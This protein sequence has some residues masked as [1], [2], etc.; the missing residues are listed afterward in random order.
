MM[1]IVAAL[2]K[3]AAEAI[4]IRCN[5]TCRSIRSSHCDMVFREGVHEI[6]K[7]AKK[8]ELEKAIL[9]WHLIFGD[10]KK[11]VRTSHLGLIGYDIDSKLGILFFGCRALFRLSLPLLLACGG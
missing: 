7:R 1:P 3:T 2:A 5:E 11:A 6:N 4:C 9:P 8:P 10:T